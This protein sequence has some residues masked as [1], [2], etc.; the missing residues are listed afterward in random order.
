MGLKEAIIL[1]RTFSDFGK[2]N[3]LFYLI[4]YLNILTIKKF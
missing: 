4:H 2:I 3:E 1:M